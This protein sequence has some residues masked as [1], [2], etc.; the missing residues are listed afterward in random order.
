MENVYYNVFL[1]IISIETVIVWQRLLPFTN[2]AANFP[3]SAGFEE[4]MVMPP[5]KIS[6]QY[7]SF[8]EI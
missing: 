8:S 2:P 1:N 3:I 4:I 6:L 7:E 5:A